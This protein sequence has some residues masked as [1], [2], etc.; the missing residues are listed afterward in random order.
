MKLTL[1]ISPEIDKINYPDISEILEKVPSIN[2]IQYKEIGLYQSYDLPYEY[3]YH[4]KVPLMS[5]NKNL[6]IEWSVHGFPELF[7]FS[8]GPACKKARIKDFYY[9]A[10][11]PILS[12]DELKKEIKRKLNIIK[13]NF[14]NK[15]A[16]ENTNYY[17][18]P[19]YEHVTDPEFLSEIVYENDIYFCLDV[20]HAIITSRNLDNLLK[21]YI[22]ALPLD[23]CIEVHLSKPGLVA[24]SWRDLH[25]RPAEFEFYMLERILNKAKED[26]YVVVEYNRCQETLIEVYKE[27]E[28]RFYEKGN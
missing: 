12:R 7:S 15:I 9:E 27:L 23:R 11:S 8:T 14:P 17:P 10:E 24:G 2:V 18:F 4:S 13:E 28:K 6:N 16:I 26:I 1:P 21:S 20:A 3:I 22:D 19:A 5:S 25:E